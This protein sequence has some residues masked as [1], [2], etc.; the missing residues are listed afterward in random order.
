MSLTD[1]L[2]RAESPIGKGSIDVTPDGAT[3]NDIQVDAPISDDWTEVFKRFKLDATKFEVVDDTV[4]MSTW[5][6]SKRLENGNRDTIQL[7]S[8]SARFRRVDKEMVPAETVDKWRKALMRAPSPKTKAVV[9]GGTYLILVADPQLGKKNTDQAVA[10][11]KRGVG[12]HL[13]E[14]VRLQKAGVTVR[15]VHVAFMGDETE[16]V[17][18]N[19][20]NQAHTIELNQSAQL[21]LDFDMRVWT[22]RQ[23]ATLALPTSV[24][25]IVSNHGEWTRNGSKDPVTTQGDNAS[26]SVA[27]LVKRLFDELEPHGGPKIRWTIAGGDPGVIVKLSGIDCYFSHGHIEKGRGTSSETRTRAAIERQILGRTDTLGDVPLWFFAHYHHKYSNEFE[28]RTVFGCPALEAD[29][30]SEYMLNQFGVWSPPGMLGML[31]GGTGARKWSHAT[32]H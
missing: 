9:V 32:V 14:I 6:Q 29:R 25:S 26:T 20:A 19:Y 11:W 8:Y 10:N 24:S 3:L 17:A 21:E 28:G 16:G 27:R 4:R 30:S 23:V 22:I 1:A 12:G 18:N 13:G 31:I 2:D 15:G 5:E 7:Y